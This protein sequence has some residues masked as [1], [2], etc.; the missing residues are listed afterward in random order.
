MININSNLN[1]DLSCLE[2][3][4]KIVIKPN[5]DG[6]Y[7]LA[8]KIE[9]YDENTKKTKKATISF[10]KTEINLN[11]DVLPQIK[12]KSESFIEFKV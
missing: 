12:D 11:V 3:A 6:T 2:A 9:M 10:M 7:N 8:F 4:K 5:E 1:F